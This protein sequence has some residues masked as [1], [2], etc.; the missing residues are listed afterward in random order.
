MLKHAY[1]GGVYR[2]LQ[3]VGIAPSRMELI[4]RLLEEDAVEKEIA[5]QTGGEELLQPPT[6][7]AS[8]KA[9]P[10]E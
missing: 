2:A 7:P 3:N 6:E 4:K 9:L 1:I 8:A 5:A 10:G